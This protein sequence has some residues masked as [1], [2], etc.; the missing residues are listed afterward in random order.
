[1]RKLEEIKTNMESQNKMISTLL[2][3]SR[4]NPDLC[5]EIPEELNMPLLTIDD[6]NAAET[7]LQKEPVANKLVL[8]FLF[9]A[10]K[11][12]FVL[13]TGIQSFP[14]MYTYVLVSIFISE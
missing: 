4:V 14:A 2:Q 1:M 12:D 6:V 8:T 11:K 7:H 3:Q 10:W 13:S 5:S 9:L